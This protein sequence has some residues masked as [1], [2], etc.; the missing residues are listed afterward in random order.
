MIARATAADLAVAVAELKSF[1]RDAE[2]VHNV[3]LTIRVRAIH[4]LALRAQGRP[5]AALNSLA[6][7]L[8]LAEPGGFVRTFLDL[9]P[10]LVAL[11]RGL[12]ARRPPSTHL[13]RLLAV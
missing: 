5:E 10:P 3:W 13:D 9:G 4:G 12:A 11:L 6:S 2:R 7:A 1:L 8:A